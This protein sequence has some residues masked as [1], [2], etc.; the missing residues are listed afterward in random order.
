MKYTDL[1]MQAKVQGE[2][3]TVVRAAVTSWF[4]KRKASNQKAQTE[5]QKES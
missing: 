4:Q 3:G 2:E 1:T 5:R